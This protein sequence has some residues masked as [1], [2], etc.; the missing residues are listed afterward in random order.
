MQISSCIKQSISENP[1]LIGIFNVDYNN[2]EYTNSVHQL[3]EPL[4]YIIYYMYLYVCIVCVCRIASAM[5]HTKL[6]YGKIAMSYVTYNIEIISSNDLYE[7][8]TLVSATT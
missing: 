4:Y 2:R 3:H 7:D 5:F 8:R 1:Q 6:G